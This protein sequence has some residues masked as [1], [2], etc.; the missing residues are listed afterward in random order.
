MSALFTI[1]NI[2]LKAK[3]CSAYFLL[4][5][6]EVSKKWLTV[7]DFNYKDI[8]LLLFTYGKQIF[9]YALIFHGSVQYQKGLIFLFTFRAAD[10]SKWNW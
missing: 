7:T 10:T 1:A 9:D 5:W 2:P 8:L 6:A 4:I 3:N